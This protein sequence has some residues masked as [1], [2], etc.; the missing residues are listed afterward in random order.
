MTTATAQLPTSSTRTATARSAPSIAR[1]IVLWTISAAAAA[2]FAMSGSAKLLGAPTMVQ[3][4]DTIGIG[5]WFR[6][7]TGGIEVIGALALLVPSA[8]VYAAV[9]LAATMIGASIAHL[10][11]IGGSAAVPAVLLGAT[12]FVGWTR[13][14]QR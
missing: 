1:T 5:Q 10:F 11:I 12:A 9:V 7:V 8:A 2:V 4:F 6:Y 13:W 3:L 14:S